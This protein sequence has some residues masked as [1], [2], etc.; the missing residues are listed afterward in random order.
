MSATRLRVQRPSCS[1]RARS[2]SRIASTDFS[3]TIGHR[4][5]HLHALAAQLVEQRLDAVRERGDVG[6]AERRA[7]A[8]DRMG[9]AE[10]GVDQLRLGRSEVELQ[11]RGLHAVER[12]EAL[13]EERAV[14]LGEIERHASTERAGEAERLRRAW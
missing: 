9:D 12:L 13:F 5:R 6:E 2:I 1:A 7:A 10:N 3:S 4:L 8:L 14:E 11:E